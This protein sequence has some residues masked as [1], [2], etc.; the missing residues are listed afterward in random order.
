MKTLERPFLEDYQLDA[1]T[2]LQTGSILCGRL[3]REN[4]G[5]LSP[6]IFR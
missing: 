5:L 2:R 3:D 1:L 4:L 6:I